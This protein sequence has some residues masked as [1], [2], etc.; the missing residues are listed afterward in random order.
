MVENINC[1]QWV[2]R[3]NKTIYDEIN[4]S[5]LQELLIHEHNS[6]TIVFKA[7]EGQLTDPTLSTISSGMKQKIHTIIDYFHPECPKT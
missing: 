5:N 4:C 3:T 2:D 7:L 1:H 6:L